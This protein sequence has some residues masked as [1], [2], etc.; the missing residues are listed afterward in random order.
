MLKILI[1]HHRS[2]VAHKVVEVCDRFGVAPEHLSISRVD[3]ETLAV[4]VD[5]DRGGAQFDV[6]E[7]LVKNAFAAFDA[8]PADPVETD[9][10]EAA[11]LQAEAD[12]KVEADNVAAAAEAADT[13]AAKAAA[14]KAAAV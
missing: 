10:A 11:A 6:V 14:G 7:R 4:A 13:A 8:P 9:A 12:S 2:N 3:D 5:G 1:T